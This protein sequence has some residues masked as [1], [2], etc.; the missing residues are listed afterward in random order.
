MNFSQII[1]NLNKISES[2]EKYRAQLIANRYV[3]RNSNPIPKDVLPFLQKHVK[4]V[5][6]YLIIKQYN[7]EWYQYTFKDQDV[8]DFQSFFKKYISPYFEIINTDGL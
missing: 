8:V 3:R 7:P 6:T 2:K 1:Q 5:D 4:K